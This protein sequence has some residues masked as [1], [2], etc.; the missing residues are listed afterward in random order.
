MTAAK[1]AKGSFRGLSSELA[2][3][4]RKTHRH[5]RGWPHPQAKADD[6][7][8]PR[9]WT[10]VGIVHFRHDENEAGQARERQP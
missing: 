2:M 1:S 8:A 5:D 10:T 3:F 9:H 7:S 4:D 6:S